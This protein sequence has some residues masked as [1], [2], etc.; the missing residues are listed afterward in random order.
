MEVYEAY[1][2]HLLEKEDHSF[3]VDPEKAVDIMVEF[4]KRNLLVK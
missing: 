2:F 1:E 4:L 3:A